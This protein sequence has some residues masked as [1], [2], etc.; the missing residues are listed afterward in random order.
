MSEVKREKIKITEPDSGSLHFLY[1][2]AFGRLLLKLLTCR[3]ISVIGGAYMNS[4]FSRHRIKPFI[5]ENSINMDDFADTDYRSYNE[6]FTRK[7]K[8]GKRPVSY[9]ENSFISPCDSKLTVY[10]INP[11]SRF[12][13]KGSYYSVEELLC[14]KSLAEDYA[15]G[16]CLIFRLAVDDYHRYC[17]IDNGSQEN[18]IYIKGK[19]HTVQPIALSHCNIYKRNCREF[20]VLH[21]E[22]FGDVVQVEVGALMVG[23]ISNAH[24][25]YSFVRGEEKGM[26]EFGGSTIVLLVKN[27]TVSINSE[28]LT[29]TENGYETVVKYGEKIGEK[30]SVNK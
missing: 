1:K 4:R 23:K 30:V 17:Y 19:L 18:N 21:T 15:N 25:N 20:T 22:N 7:I 16:Y 29:N 10:K 26:F 14:N 28:I 13:I 8:D 6:F 24:E 9:A 27:D 11:D 2:N 5:K 12:M 3:F